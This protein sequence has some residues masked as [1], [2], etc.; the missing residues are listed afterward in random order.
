MCRIFTCLC[1]VLLLAACSATSQKRSL[2]EVIDDA[3]ITTKLKTKYMKDG[4]V[5]NKNVKLKV[6]KGVVQLSGVLHSQLEINR[7]IEIA[8][9]QKGVKE[10]KAYLVLKDM[11]ELR[12]VAGR[13]KTA[14]PTAPSPVLQKTDPGQPDVLEEKDLTGTALEENL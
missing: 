11:G 6:R 1:L 7:V 10:V 5:D 8:E 4:V 12:P 3:V 14:P 2:G 13:R 9:K